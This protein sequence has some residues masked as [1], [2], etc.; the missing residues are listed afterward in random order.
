MIE[1]NYSLKWIE[2][3]SFIK[4]TFSLTFFM[5]LFF[6]LQQIL[7]TSRTW[8]PSQ[9][10]TYKLPMRYQ[11]QWPILSHLTFS[12]FSPLDIIFSLFFKV[13]SKITMKFC[14]PVTGKLF[15]E[16]Y[17]FLNLNDLTGK[18]VKNLVLLATMQKYYKKLKI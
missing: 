11:V 13:I 10:T 9:Q 16:E 15:T 4:N 3:T 5:A 7:C 18:E 2:I 17:V 6:L 8:K 14:Q 12:F 1:D